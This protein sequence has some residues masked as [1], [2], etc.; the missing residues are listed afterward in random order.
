MPGSLRGRPTPLPWE[1]MAD[2][3]SGE[4]QWMGELRKLQS[5]LSRRYEPLLWHALDAQARTRRARASVPTF[6]HCSIPVALDNRVLPAREQ[7][8]RLPVLGVA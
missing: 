7:D 8:G 5:E 1:A 4:P 2:S 3:P 6:I